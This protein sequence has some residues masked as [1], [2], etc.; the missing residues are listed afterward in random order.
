MSSPAQEHLLT[1]ITIPTFETEREE[2][3]WWRDNSHLFEN[4]FLKAIKS[5]IESIP[6]E[7]M[8]V[9]R[10]NCDDDE[11]TAPQSA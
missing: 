10:Q 5:E 6:V 9:K 2:A 1:M 11:R 4:L 8:Q 3:D 7:E